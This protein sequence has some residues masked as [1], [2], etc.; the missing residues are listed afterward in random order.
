MIAETISINTAITSANISSAPTTSRRS[1]IPASPS[2]SGITSMTHPLLHR[3]VQVVV[4]PTRHVVGVVHP[5]AVVRTPALG[6]AGDRPD[7]ALPDQV[8]DAERFGVGL[9]P[10]GDLPAV[11]ELLGGRVLTDR[12]AERQI[13]RPAQGMLRL[14]AGAG[15]VAAPPGVGKLGESLLIQVQHPGGDLTV[16]GRIVDHPVRV[17]T[18]ERCRVTG[19]SVG[20]PAAVGRSG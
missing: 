8:L 3:D 13:T 1:P 16:R 18:V 9:H 12:V 15:R 10:L 7:L 11:V 6:I 14:S 2:K 5:A 20:A 19:G 4:V 17:V